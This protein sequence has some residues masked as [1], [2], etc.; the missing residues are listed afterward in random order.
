VIEGIAMIEPHGVPDRFAAG[1]A[2]YRS[3]WFFIRLAW[4]FIARGSWLLRSNAKSRPWLQQ[5]RHL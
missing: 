5:S 3:A 4:C 2:A 1:S